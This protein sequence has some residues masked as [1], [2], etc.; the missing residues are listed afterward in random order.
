MTSITGCIV[1]TRKS[2]LSSINGRRDIK[3]QRRRA[4]ISELNESAWHISLFQFNHAEG[5]F[6]TLAWLTNLFTKRWNSE[7]REL[8]R[9]DQRQ[10]RHENKFPRLRGS[11]Y[12]RGMPQRSHSGPSHHSLWESNSEGRI[13]REAQSAGF[14]TWWWVPQCLTLD[15]LR[16][17]FKTLIQN[18][19]L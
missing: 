12:L 13:P 19:S 8:V 10:L 18:Y 1:P 2:C 6:F 5:S 11:T 9:S 14:S 16:I 15:W 4:S 3:Q 7:T 17:Q